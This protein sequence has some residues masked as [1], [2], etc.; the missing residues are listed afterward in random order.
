MLIPNNIEKKDLAKPACAS[1]TV[2]LNH[3]RL[4]MSLTNLQRCYD[5]EPFGF[6][7]NLNTLDL[8]QPRSLVRLCEI[9]SE[10]NRGYF[11]SA[12]APSGGTDF[13]SVPHG[14]L[15]PDK[16]MEQLSSR[17]LRILLKRPETQDSGFRD[18]LNLLFQQIADLCG[19]L[20]NEHVLRL[21]SAVLITSAATIT[22]I[23]FD[24]VIGFFSQIEGE[25]KYHVYSPADTD[26][27][28]L[29][30]FY[31]R[32]VFDI[33]AVKL[34]NRNPAH[35]HVFRLNAG[36][37][38]H[39]PQ[40][41]CHWVETGTNRSVSY[42]FVFQTDA[43]QALGR[44]RAFNHYERKLGVIP[45]PPGRHPHCDKVKGETMRVVIPLRQKVS[46][47]LEGIRKT[48]EAPRL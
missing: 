39:Q 10:S 19:I 34:E 25:K 40:N 12:G 35:E 16:A 43:T 44:T 32:G 18:L 30:R 3:A 22:P 42:T 23:H 17:P 13:Y 14:G 47:I 33:G 29:E 36:A 15:M 38:F 1:G 5:R 45:A 37:A 6:S 31:I 8:F 41:A 46:H 48:S 27:R 20:S 11:I 28:D 9:F 4:D 24:P 7:H 2:N 26:E 21:E